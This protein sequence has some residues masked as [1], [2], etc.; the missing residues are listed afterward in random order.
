MKILII[1]NLYKP[2]ARGGGERVVEL[3]VDEFRRL[4]HEI[5]I[6]T[7]KPCRASSVESFD[8]KNKVYYL[9]SKYYNLVKIPLFLRLFWHVFDMFN[10]VN[11]FKINSILQKEKCDLVLTHNLKGVGLLATHAIRKNKIKN[12]H[13]LHDIQ[14]FYPSGLMMYGKEKRVDSL[15]AKIY[16]K[17][18]SLLIDSPRVVVSPSQWLLDEHL[19]RGFFK[20]SGCIVLPNP[21]ILRETK[22]IIE[23]EGNKTIFNLLYVGQIENHKGVSFLVDAFNSL[24]RDDFNLHIVG[25]G[26][27]IESIK[28]RAAQNNKIFFYGR[29]SASEVEELMCM[30]DC[31]MV[32]SLCYENS[33]TVIYE[34]ASVNLPVIA[35]RIGGIT[36]LVRKIGG[37]LFVPGDAPDLIKKIQ[38]AKANQELLKKI[39]KIHKIKKMAIEEYAKKLS[40][41]FS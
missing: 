23:R 41:Y 11:Y 21:V 28:S 26:S 15:L 33:P 37:I 13:T 24:S 34:A 22:E 29:K 40:C 19:K 5:I 8:S 12:I 25:D 3:I 30:A 16:S 14:L 6:I 7:T 18:N 38:W 39:I 1:N 27:E 2:Y 35:A 4:G 10:F 36:E 20:N 31:L 9:N 17:V 32:P